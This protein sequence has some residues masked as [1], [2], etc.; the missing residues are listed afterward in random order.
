MRLGRGLL[1][2]REI[3]G[4]P[5]VDDL[6]LGDRAGSGEPLDALELHLGTLKGRVRLAD[7]LR[8]DDGPDAAELLDA[9]ARLVD[10]GLRLRDGGARL[11]VVDLHEQLAGLHALSLDRP[12]GDHES[13]RLRRD[14]HARRHPDASAR[15][16][17]LLEIL[18]RRERDLHLRPAGAQED[19]DG[20]DDRA[21]EDEPQ[22]GSSKELRH[23]HG[24]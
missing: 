2:A 1:R 8:R 18:P 11:R 14:L 20:G 17:V 21:A 22:P 24:S 5:G 12:H 19:R 6:G 3:D 23:A 4:A 9:R 7:G 16:D 10:R 13:R 15:D